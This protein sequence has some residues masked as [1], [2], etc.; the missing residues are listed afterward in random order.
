MGFILGMT[1]TVSLLFLI[2][3]V[4]LLKGVNI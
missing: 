4:C 2:S 1:G 3:I